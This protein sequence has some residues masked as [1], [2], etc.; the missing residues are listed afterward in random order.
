MPVEQTTTKAASTTA[1]V[2]S[3]VDRE[4]TEAI[5]MTTNSVET[6]DDGSSL[7][8]TSATTED[9]SGEVISIGITI[10]LTFTNS[11]VFGC[12]DANQP[13]V[14]RLLVNSVF[15]V[16]NVTDFNRNTTEYTSTFLEFSCESIVLEVV[17]TDPVLISILMEDIDNADDFAVDS[18]ELAAEIIESDSSNLLD[19][20]EFTVAVDVDAVTVNDETESDNDNSL[21]TDEQLAILFL[22]AVGV[23]AVALASYVG[24]KLYKKKRGVSLMSSKQVEMGVNTDTN[25]KDGDI[26][27]SALRLTSLSSASAS[28]DT[29]EPDLPE[30][31]DFVIGDTGETRI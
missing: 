9:N 15:G 20:S 18:N 1:G 27:P 8:T 12:D 24:Y 25:N 11:S 21:F 19:G 22:I 13:Y 2:S 5:V 14:E 16:L 6:T 30:T 10:E 23:C 3:T 26:V 17:I 31:T 4:T 7:E 28:A 29:N